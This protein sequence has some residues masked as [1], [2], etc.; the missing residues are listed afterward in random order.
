MMDP[1]RMGYY[2]FIEGEWT[3]LS[4]YVSSV[5]VRSAYAQNHP[6]Y[7]L[8]GYVGWREMIVPGRWRPLKGEPKPLQMM[9]LVGA[10]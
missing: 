6:I 8:A 10:I 2:S 5:H 4:P 9:R 7:W 3:Y 1:L